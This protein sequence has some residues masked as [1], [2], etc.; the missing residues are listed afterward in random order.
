MECREI[1]NP[2]FPAGPAHVTTND[3]NFPLHGEWE[4]EVRAR[5]GDFDLVT[6][7]GTVIV[8]AC[9]CCAMSDAQRS[10]GGRIPRNCT[11]SSRS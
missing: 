6:V 11:R 5:D 4:V 3:A 7:D 9:P 2:T 1:V 10:S 8:R